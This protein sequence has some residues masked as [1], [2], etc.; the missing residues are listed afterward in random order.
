MG[1]DLVSV[2]IPT[3]NRSQQT[4]RAAYSVL[5]QSGVG[6]FFDLE[7]IVVDDCSDEVDFSSLKEGLQDT[8][9]RIIRSEKN[10]GGPAIP[11]NLGI[12]ASKGNWLA[13]LDSDDMWRE[14]KLISQLEALQNSGLRACGS[15]SISI[16]TSHLFK[17][18][19]R[20]VIKNSTLTRWHIF[21]GNA[22]TTSSMLIESGVVNCSGKFPQNNKVNFYEDYAYWLRVMS[23]TDIALTPG[24]LVVYDSSGD[25]KRSLNVFDHRTALRETFRDFDAWLRTN[26]KYKL[27]VMERTFLQLQLLLA[28]L[29]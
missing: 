21:L 27:G 18:F 28:W 6:E 5:A 12:E 19:K 23:F 13:F 26:P 15:S 2:I 20:L 17:I 3:Y 14:A 16:N 7:V 9:V 8:K 4:I 10:S 11:R 29:K 22:L 1:L 24:Q 25:A